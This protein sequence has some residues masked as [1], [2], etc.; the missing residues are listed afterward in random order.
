[1]GLGPNPGVS[2]KWGVKRGRVEFQPS[3]GSFFSRFPCPPPYEVGWAYTFDGA[4]KD[5]E[6]ALPPIEGRMDVIPG[7]WRTFYFCPACE[8]VG[9]KKRTNERTKERGND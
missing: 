5:H 8:R 3:M 1:M 4:R 6:Y 2:S 7:R 9:Y